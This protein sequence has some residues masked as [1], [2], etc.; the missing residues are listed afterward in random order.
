MDELI[1]RKRLKKSICNYVKTYPRYTKE[2]ETFYV[3]Y[4]G[5][6][7]MLI[8]IVK[9]INDM[10]T[11]QP[12]ILDLIKKIRKYINSNDRGSSDYF[13]V[14]KIEEILDEYEQGCNLQTG[15]D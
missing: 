12:E 11:E 4:S 10:P 14:D 1:N 6:K 9:I 3:T 15:S 8:D 5:G 13:I 7:K 2:G